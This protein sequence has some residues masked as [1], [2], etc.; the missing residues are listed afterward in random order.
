MHIFLIALF[1]FKHIYS[2]ETKLRDQAL[3]DIC[4][5]ELIA[6]FNP[7]EKLY[8]STNGTSIT[9]SMTLRSNEQFKLIRFGNFWCLESNNFKEDYISISINEAN[10][11]TI[12]KK[13]GEN[14]QFD[15]INRV[16]VGK[17]YYALRSVKYN[18]FLCV[19]RNA[20]SNE[21]FR[22]NGHVNVQ[23]SAVNEGDILFEFMNATRGDVM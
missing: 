20:T 1:I 22:D 3:T 6:I 4:E 18:V 11:V 15:I 10:N 14:E 23:Q 12:S 7:E 8:I 16:D 21:S 19:E 5:N 9:T 13:C 2:N 17:E